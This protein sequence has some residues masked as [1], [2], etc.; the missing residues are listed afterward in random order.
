MKV[1]DKKMPVMVTGGTGYM[2][3]WIIKML[4]EEGISVNATVRDPLDIQKVG[5]LTALAKGS[6]GKLKLFKADL[7]DSGSFDEPMQGCGLVIHAASAHIKAGFTPT[8]SGRHIL[9]SGEARLLDIANILRKHF[10][11]GFPYYQS[12]VKRVHTA[13]R[14]STMPNTIS[15]GCAFFVRTSTIKLR[16]AKNLPYTVAQYIGIIL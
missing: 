4:L 13:P 8:A 11:E 6:P 10:G 2:A 9:V 14:A 1:I 15:I 5:H 12:N 7:L 16:N 3:S